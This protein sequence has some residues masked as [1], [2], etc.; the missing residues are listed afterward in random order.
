MSDV[1]KI[2]SAKIGKGIEALQALDLGKFA[3]NKSATSKKSSTI[4][5][6]IGPVGTNE[7][8]RTI[9]T[10]CDLVGTN[11][12]SRSI[13]VPSIPVRTNK[14]SPNIFELMGANQKSSTN[15]TAPVAMETSSQ[16]TKPQPISA[17]IGPGETSS[18]DSSFKPIALPVEPKLSTTVKPEDKSAAPIK[19]RVTKFSAPPKQPPPPPQ[20]EDSEDD[21]VIVDVQPGDPPSPTRQKPTTVSYCLYLFAC[22]SAKNDPIFIL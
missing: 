9:P 22:N 5:T 20:D 19:P 1:F 4:S 2:G 16:E 14:D 15:L 8:G 6:P 10:S 3:F 11:E 18:T 13:S 12:E 21:C 17:T 7:T